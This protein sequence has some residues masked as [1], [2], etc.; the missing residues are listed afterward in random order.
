MK[1]DQGSRAERSCQGDPLTL[2]IPHIPWKI[3]WVEYQ[4]SGGGRLILSIRKV[5]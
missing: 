1:K 4:V 3:G 2:A 5:P